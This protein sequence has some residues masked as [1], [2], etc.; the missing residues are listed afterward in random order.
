MFVRI[1]AP[2]LTD[3]AVE[4]VES[5]HVSG[6]AHGAGGG[7]TGGHGAVLAHH[8]G[9]LGTLVTRLSAG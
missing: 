6:A 2:T 5:K 1:I 4:G 8:F 7:A 3:G 9:I